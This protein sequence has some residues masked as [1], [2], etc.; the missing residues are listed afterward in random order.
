MIS[1]TYLVVKNSTHAQVLHTHIQIL[2]P[3]NNIQLCSYIMFF[4]GNIKAE[5]QLQYFEIV[6]A[7]QQ[8]IY[9]IYLTIETKYS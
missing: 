1:L 3:F 7:L 2:P 8:I 5:I 9:G 6:R 4:Y